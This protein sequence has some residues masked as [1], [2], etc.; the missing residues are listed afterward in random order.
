MEERKGPCLKDIG[1]K[2]F[3][4]RIFQYVDTPL[5][6]FNDDASAIE[7]PSGDILVIN[8][9]MLVQ[10]T[11]VLPGMSSYQIGQKAVTMAV[12][13]IVAK[14]VNPVGCLASVGF[15]PTLNVNDAEEIIRGIKHQCTSYDC[16]FLGGDLNESKE[17]IVDVVSFGTCSKTTLIPRKGASSGDLVYS[18][19]TFGLT[20]LGFEVL[21]RGKEIDPTLRVKVLEAVY[22]PSAKNEFLTILQNVP[23]RVCM[24]T[25]DGLLVTLTDLS[26]INDLGINVTSLPINP[27]VKE[28]AEKNELNPLD[29]TFKGGEEFEL[30]FAIPPEAKQELESKVKELRLDVYQLGIFDAN[31]KGIKVTDPSFSAFKLPKNGYEHFAND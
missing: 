3:L 31:I 22:E 18:T 14:G 28:Y 16:L 20:S 29:L 2:G 10:G 30:I 1:E 12:S 15:S 25:S 24:D 11:D 8:V 27:E 23:I 13:D 26:S 21:L 4:S 5:I 9:D 6:E 19:G 17:T 7:L